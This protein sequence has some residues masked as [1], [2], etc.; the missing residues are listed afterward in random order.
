MIGVDRT[1][2]IIQKRTGAVIMSHS[3]REDVYPFEIT[4]FPAAAYLL[5]KTNL[6]SSFYTGIDIS[7]GI[8]VNVLTYRST[9]ET[10]GMEDTVFIK[11]Y[12]SPSLLIGYYFFP[13]FSLSVFCSFTMVIYPDMIFMA[14]TPGI[15]LE[16]SF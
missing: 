3:G 5:A 7:G 9:E 1:I 11:P 14:P 8:V 15:K 12:I 16:W 13:G 4:A 10:E 2:S 6:N